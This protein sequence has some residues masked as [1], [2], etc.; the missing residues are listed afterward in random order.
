MNEKVIVS[1][2]EKLLSSYNKL[3]ESNSYDCSNIKEM[4]EILKKIQKSL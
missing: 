2:I 3:K 4:R 1:Q